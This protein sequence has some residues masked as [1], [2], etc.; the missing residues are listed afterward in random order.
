MPDMAEREIERLRAELSELDRGLVD[1]VNRRLR[2]VA[3]LKR[4][5]EEQGVA[6]LDPAR[7]EYM[8]GWLSGENPGP[9]TDEGLRELYTELLALTKRELGRDSG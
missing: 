3:K 8:L 2:L 7:E 5:K 4:V 9:L 1:G 6:F